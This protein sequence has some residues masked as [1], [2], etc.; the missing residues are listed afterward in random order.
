MYWQLRYKNHYR[1]GL[2]M[3]SLAVKGPNE[4]NLEEMYLKVVTGP[5]DN[6]LRRGFIKCP[7]CGDEIL[8]IPTLRQMNQAIENHVKVHKEMLSQRPLLKQQTAMQIRLDLAQQVLEQASSP[9]LF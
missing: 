9:D 4:N 8:M 5:N 6:I 7:E 3:E 1:V 2:G